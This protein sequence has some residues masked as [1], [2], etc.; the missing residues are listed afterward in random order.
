VAFTDKNNNDSFDNADT[1]IAGIIDANNDGVVS[2]GDTVKW[3]T[4]P[5]LDGTSA[6]TFTHGDSPITDVNAAT[7]TGVWVDVAE[8]EISW[9]ALSGGEA[10]G[11][12]VTTP[13]FQLES[14]MTDDFNGQ[15]LVADHVTVDSTVNG[16]GAP[17]MSVS[18]GILQQASGDQ[19][20]LDVFII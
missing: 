4:Y 14:S 19:G 5:H 16:P 15:V 10:F 20:F 2:V 1:L 18:E 9:T 8:G 13:F 3:G 11:T 17:N 7:S 6:G 12:R